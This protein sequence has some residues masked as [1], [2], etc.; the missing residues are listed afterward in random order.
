[1]ICI[2]LFFKYKIFFMI[3]KSINLTVF[4]YV[5]SILLISPFL[6]SL[7]HFYNF[8][9]YSLFFISV[10][11]AFIINNFL[12]FIDD[13]TDF[14][15]QIIKSHFF[16]VYL[17]FFLK[18]ENNVREKKNALLFGALFSILLLIFYKALI[19]NISFKFFQFFYFYGL[20]YSVLVYIKIRNTL[21][22]NKAL[23]LPESHYLKW[24][25]FLNFYDIKQ[26]KIQNLKNFLY[27][28]HE[29]T[30]I[31][32]FYTH[33]P[34]FE[35]F[36]NIKKL[37]FYVMK[38]VFAFLSTLSSYVSY[39]K[40]VSSV[41]GFDGIRSVI[42]TEI[43]TC[44]NLN[45]NTISIIKSSGDISEEDDSIVV[46]NAIKKWR[47]DRIAKLND[48][49]LTLQKL[50]EK[51]K[52]LPL[53]YFISQKNKNLLKEFH[54]VLRDFSRSSMNKNINLQVFI[55][56]MN[57]SIFLDAETDEEADNSGI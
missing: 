56:K 57:F 52:D 18:I 35:L 38:F 54:E 53:I 34:F 8:P 55:K 21:I 40:F 27:K 3:Q 13:K 42:L 26:P 46:Q 10:P 19:D 11:A 12:S 49:L 15:R 24:H 16:F 37:R 31:T 44:R 51:I 23:D 30:N 48:E 7:I 43:R 20:Y 33:N 50:N 45:K 28:N 25:D 9:W 47:L 17:L 14:M 22:N 2:S 39:S 6:K 41:D 5:L 36:D 32:P 1:M 29:F 4:S